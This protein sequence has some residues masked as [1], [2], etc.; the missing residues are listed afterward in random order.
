MLGLQVTKQT[1]L[2]PLS[3]KLAYRKTA[4]WDMK[5]N[6]LFQQGSNFATDPQRIVSA[7]YW[8]VVPLAFPFKYNAVS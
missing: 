8:Y 2:P 4:L 3:L 1:L 6:L 7:F 5:E